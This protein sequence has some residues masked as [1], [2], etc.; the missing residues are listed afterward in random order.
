MPIQLGEMVSKA[1]R[2]VFG[3]AYSR[4]V[5][6]L[7]RGLW[8]G[9]YE[10]EEP[11][12]PAATSF[13]LGQWITPTLLKSGTKTVG[14]VPVQLCSYAMS[15][16]NT[17][18][19][20]SYVQDASA[21]DLSLAREGHYVV[22]TSGFA[23]LIHTVD[24]A[25]NK[26]YIHEWFWHGQSGW[27]RA[28]NIP[29]AGER[30]FL[31]YALCAKSIEIR[32]S[33]ISSN[34]VWIGFNSAVSPNNGFPLLPTV[35]NYSRSII[36]RSNKAFNLTEI[37][38]VGLVEQDVEWAIGM[39]S[40][41]AS[42]YI[43]PSALESLSV[44]ESLP[45]ADS[46]AL[47][48]EESIS[49]AL[50]LSDQVS[51]EIEINV[52]EQL[53]MSEGVATEEDSGSVVESEL[54]VSDSLS[55]SDSVSLQSAVAETFS[56]VYSLLTEGGCANGIAVDTTNFYVY[57]ANDG[58]PLGDGVY[59]YDV[60]EPSSPVYLGIYTTDGAPNHVVLIDEDHIALVDYDDIHI[61]DVTD[62]AN[63]V[64]VTSMAVTGEPCWM[65]INGTLISA[66]PSFALIDVSDPDVPVQ[67]YNDYDVPHLLD[68]D[69]IDSW[70]DSSYAYVISENAGVVRLTVL[71]ISTTVNPNILS[72]TDF[73]LIA[74]ANRIDVYDDYAYVAGSGGLHIIDISDK[75]APVLVV[76]VPTKTAIEATAIEVVQ[77]AGTIYAHVGT[78]E[79]DP[80]YIIL[81]VTD[82]L[83][84]A[85]IGEFE[86]PY[87]VFV[88]STPGVIDIFVDEVNEIAYVGQNWAAL[89][90][91][92]ISSL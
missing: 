13:G 3:T 24:D 84:I 46:V 38:V 5:S 73:A 86:M 6:L 82:P 77:K 64:L 76:T 15:S 91:F 31:F 81:D 8:A 89:H 42:G 14:V 17:L 7:T 57:L 61:I 78:S 67:D 92:D 37:F 25:N 56:T 79:D 35:G 16:E 83:N 20:A 49:D 41:S 29:S 66:S 33:N 80:W 60:S 18:Y 90:L 55:I 27:R 69:G 21:W 30:A 12:I 34:A 36:L 51:L 87:N 47:E 43:T 74:T 59:I 22:T 54:N 10:Y 23:G 39:R 45:L 75:S 85:W 50:G 40:P 72:E 53:N 63:P 32:P 62:K 88:D 71:D 48:A 52:G 44:S 68:Y 9:F 65:H 4:I 70:H 1:T 58:G 11:D 26:V 28:A 19:T 2:G